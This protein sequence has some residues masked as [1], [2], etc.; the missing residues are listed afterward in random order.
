M[1]RRAWPRVNG[2]HMTVQPG[3]D[4]PGMSVSKTVQPVDNSG[5]VADEAAFTGLA[6]QVCRGSWLLVG[7]PSRVSDLVA[8]SRGVFQQVG[9]PIGGTSGG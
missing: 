9:M 2:C 7:T 3:E 1:I 6:A 5:P 8:G 4:N